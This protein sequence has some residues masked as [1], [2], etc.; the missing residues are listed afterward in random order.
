MDGQL[1][2]ALESLARLKRDGENL[3]GL[4]GLL[5]T[6]YRRSATIIDMLEDRATP[7]EIGKSMAAPDASRH[8]RDRPSPAWARARRAPR[9]VR[10]VGALRA[11]PFKQGEI[12]EEVGFEV[13]IARLCARSRRQ[14]VPGAG[15]R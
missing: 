10:R 3:Q 13:L 5:Q 14:C 11:H 1:G 12:D 6:G 9:G 2:N 8:L 4:L 15:S 7:E